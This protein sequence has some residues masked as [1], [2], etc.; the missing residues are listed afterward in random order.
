MLHQK[1]GHGIQR[2]FERHASLYLFI[3]VLFVMGIIFGT[4]TVQS[5]GHSQQADLV[6]YFE[7][8]MSEMKEDHIV[9]PSYAFWQS[10]I[11]YMKYTGVIWLLGLSIIGLPIILI[12]L[13]LK[14]VFVGFSVGF[15]V[16]QLGWE[17]FL[18]SLVSVIPQNMVVVPLILLMSVL[19][20]SFSLQL[21]GYIFGQ[22]RVKRKPRLGYYMAI[23]FGASLILFVVALFETYISPVFMRLIG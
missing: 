9:E 7:Q 6:F 18:L 19:S 16:H 3:V 23:M 4:V 12:L 15:L 5:L 1:M 21:I 10:F 17:G 13:F 20:I 22:N 8:F 2:H 11:H 14:G